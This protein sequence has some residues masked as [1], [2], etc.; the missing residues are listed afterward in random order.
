MRQDQLVDRALALSHTIS[1]ADAKILRVDD[2]VCIMGGSKYGKSELC[3]VVE[4]TD[5]MVYVRDRYGECF[6][7]KKEHVK[8]IYLLSNNGRH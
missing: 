1:A 4:L 6:Q 2:K 8:K 5:K 7:K 3:T